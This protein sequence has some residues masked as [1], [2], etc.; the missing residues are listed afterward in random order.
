MFALQCL[1]DIKGVLFMAIRLS[2]SITEG[3]IDE[4]VILKEKV[5]ML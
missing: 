2:K 3:K 4:S 5:L 1:S